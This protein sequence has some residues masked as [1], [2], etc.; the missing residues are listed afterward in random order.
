MGIFRIGRS[1]RKISE[2]MY[3]EEKKIK[4][5]YLTSIY[6]QVQTEISKIS[7]LPDR[8]LLE[9]IYIELLNFKIKL[10]KF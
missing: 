6:K 7:E 5:D 4:A 1:Q 3:S 2:D 10:E 9:K 8:E